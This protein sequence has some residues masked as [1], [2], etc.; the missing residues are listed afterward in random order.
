MTNDFKASFGSIIFNY[1]AC[2]ISRFEN[3]VHNIK[4]RFNFTEASIKEKEIVFGGGFPVIGCRVSESRTYIDSVNTGDEYSDVKS[5][6]L[7]YEISKILSI[8]ELTIKKIEL[9]YVVDFDS[10]ENLIAFF[11]NCDEEQDFGDIDEAS[12]NIVYERNNLKTELSF[13]IK[14]DKPSYIFARCISQIKFMDA[15]ELYKNLN[16]VKSYLSE[17]ISRFLSNRKGDMVVHG[18]IGNDRKHG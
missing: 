7:I 13:R 2:D 12:F 18:G 8:K 14:V 11:T 10:K 5:V 15:M 17:E 9:I 1:E 3:E 4:R 16:E 6:D